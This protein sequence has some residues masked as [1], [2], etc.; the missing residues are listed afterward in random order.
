MLLNKLLS[1]K[2]NNAYE[3]LWL[4][5]IFLSF[6]F[7]IFQVVYHGYSQNILI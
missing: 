7:S 2:L 4:L 3:F 6:S 5:L 1:Y